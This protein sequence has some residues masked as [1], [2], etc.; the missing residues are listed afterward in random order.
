MSRRAPVALALAAFAL[1]AMGCATDTRAKGIAAEYHNIANAYVEMGQY[2]KA[3]P[4]YQE[5]LRADPSMVKADFNLALALGH[6]KRTAEAEAIL[7]KLLAGDPQNT[8]VLSTLGWIYHAGGR[9]EEALAQYDAAI[10][11]S[12]RNEDAL[13]N[14]GI[15]LWKLDRKQE[16]L[17]RFRSLLVGA[18]DD[19][20]AM[21]AAGSLLLALDDAPA[22]ADMLAL[23]LAKKP[24]DLD[25]WYMVAAG[26]ERQQKYSRALEAYD[27]I[28]SLDPKQGDAW[29]GEAR[30]LLTVI[31]DPQRGHDALAKSL[32]A[33]FQDP[34]AIEALLASQGLLEREKVEAALKERSLL[35][36]VEPVAAPQPSLRE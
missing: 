8:E 36:A 19:A 24:E 32:A 13:Y 17:G 15:I 26:A 34:K 3:I 29:F 1:L 21:Y 35:P 20:D 22:S 27:R 16:A 33:G 14:S 12:P 31:E 23:Y 4:Y 9:D 5:A 18:P 25:A 6:M 7:K 10:A 28:V 30:L 11:L 2:E